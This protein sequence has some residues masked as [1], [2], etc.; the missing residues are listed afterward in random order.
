MCRVAIIHKVL[1]AAAFVD[2]KRRSWNPMVIHIVD[3][4]NTERF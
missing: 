1:K 4:A 3:E 2:Y